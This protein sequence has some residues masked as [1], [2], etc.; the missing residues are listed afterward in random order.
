MTWKRCRELV[1]IA[2]GKRRGKWRF[3]DERKS[4]Q[5]KR[6][7]KFNGLCRQH[8]KIKRKIN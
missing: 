1:L 5:C 7:G 3:A 4:R 8:H 6:E 2:C